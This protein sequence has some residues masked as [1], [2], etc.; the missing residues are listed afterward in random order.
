MS[1]QEL[2]NNYISSSGSVDSIVELFKTR[3]TT[4][5]EL[6]KA[7]Q[8]YVTSNQPAVRSQGFSLLNQVMAKLSTQLLY[9]KDIDVLLNFLMTKFDDEPQILIEVFDCILSLINM[10]HYDDKNNN[11]ILIKF[12]DSYNPKMYTA[13]IRNLPLKLI[14]FIID[15]FENIDGELYIR[16]FLNVSQNEKDPSNLLTIFQIIH[17]IINKFDIG[18]YKNELFDT[19]F[20]YYPISFKSTND[21]Q[22]LQKNSLKSALSDALCSTDLFASDL[23]PNLIDKYNSTVSVDVKIDIL[24]TIAT[25]IDNFSIETIRVNFLAIWNTIKYTI[26]NFEL[27]QIVGQT[28]LIEYYQESSNEN[29]NLFAIAFE[30]LENIFGVVNDQDLLQ[31]VFDDLKKYLILETSNRKFLH[32]YLILSAFPNSQHNPQS[33]KILLEQPTDKVQF[34]R[35]ILVAL[36]Y[37]SKLTPNLFEMHKDSIFIL[38]QTS[39]S[40]SIMENSL[41]ILAIQATTTFFKNSDLFL[42]EQ[43]ILLSQLGKLLIE[44]DATNQ[45]HQVLIK[46]LIDLSFIPSFENELIAE[47]MNRLL[48]NNQFNDLIKLSTTPSLIHSMMIRLLNNEETKNSNSILDSMVQLIYKIPLE[49]DMTRYYE[50]FVNDLLL[51]YKDGS[52]MEKIYLGFLFRRI[53]N[54]LDLNNTLIQQFVD[55]VS[56]WN[57]TTSMILLGGVDKNFKLDFSFSEIVDKINQSNGI[58]KTFALSGLSSLVNKYFQLSDLNAVVQLNDVDLDIKIWCLRGLIIKNDTDGI[59][60][61]VNLLGDSTFTLSI[62]LRIIKILFLE[63]DDKDGRSLE[64]AFRKDSLGGMIKTKVCTNYTIREVWKQKLFEK[65]IKLSTD[66]ELIVLMMVKLQKSVYSSKLDEIK[67]II[68]RLISVID[69]KDVE[70]QLATFK[71]LSHLIQDDPNK[72]KSYN[73]SI[74]DASLNLLATS[75]NENVKLAIWNCLGLVVDVR[76]KDDILAACSIGL[77]DDKRIVRRIVVDVRQIWENL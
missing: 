33:L 42:Q 63:C 19:L 76:R 35:L 43:S 56:R 31:L 46:E 72:W 54:G 73:D 28:Q 65:L 44:T 17:K 74:I 52:I 66:P 9:P 16:C 50:K 37:F 59:E 39:L 30:T 8:L 10:S 57:F 22:F 41:I 47:I 62:K 40:S 64:F 20:K 75:N 18:N 4:L 5:L 14:L 2:V 25:S 55:I 21:S 32:S 77:M 49:I 36:S 69:D 61:V 12:A 7:L 29:D 38:L 53:V 23:Y 6:I 71:T 68:M 67:M 34:K 58:G 15:S 26:L 13:N 70:I 24:N 27:A 45:I 11:Q 3:K 1:I 48:I 60:Q 51:K